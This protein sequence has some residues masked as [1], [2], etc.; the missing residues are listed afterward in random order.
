M[1][2]PAKANSNIILFVAVGLFW[3]WCSPT[4]NQLLGVFR[5]QDVE[6]I[7]DEAQDVRDEDSFDEQMSDSERDE[8][9]FAPL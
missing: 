6:E 2:R 4:R 5:N 3:M 7:L 8:G 9:S 1:K